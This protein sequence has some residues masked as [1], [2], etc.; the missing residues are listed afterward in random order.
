MI[1]GEW[2][3]EDQLYYVKFVDSENGYFN[4]HPNGNPIVASN[5]EDF[6]YKTQFTLAEVEAIDPRYLDFLEEVEE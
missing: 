3:V 1:D 4:I 6:G 5:L 2:E